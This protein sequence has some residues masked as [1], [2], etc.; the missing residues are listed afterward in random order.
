MTGCE[1]SEK[2]FSS[3]V[4]TQLKNPCLDFLLLL[5]T[6]NSLFTGVTQVRQEAKKHGG[7]LQIVLQN[8]EKLGIQWLA[9]K[10]DF[11]ANYYINRVG[12]SQDYIP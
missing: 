6:V 2:D 11:L 12:L 8:F 9:E 1:I 5:S 10:L 7:Q 3:V 4:E